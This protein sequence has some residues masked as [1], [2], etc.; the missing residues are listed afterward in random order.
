MKVKEGEGGADIPCIYI[1]TDSFSLTPTN[2]IVTITIYQFRFLTA[3]VPSKFGA[4]E[5]SIPVTHE[6]LLAEFPETW[7][8]VK[9]SK[10]W[11]FT[12]PER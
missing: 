3:T 4:T 6:S 5:T 10:T 12:Q 7:N 8:I 2:T 11:E 9:C 1:H